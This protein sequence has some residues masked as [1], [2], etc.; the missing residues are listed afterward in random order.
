MH[1]SHIHGQRFQ[2]VT[3]PGSLPTDD[4]AARGWKDTVMVTTGSA[5]ELRT[6]LDNPGY[7]CRIL[8]HADMGLMG[9]PDAQ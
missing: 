8:E 1:P 7:H 3:A 9:E 2:L 6:A 5:V 4:S